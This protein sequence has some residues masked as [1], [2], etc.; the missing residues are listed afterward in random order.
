VGYSVV[1]SASEVTIVCDSVPT[2][3]AVPTN[4]SVA[5]NAIALSWTA[6]TTT[7]EIG[8]DPI[9]YYRLDF[10]NRKCYDDTALT[11]TTTFVEPDDGSWV[12][13][14]SSSTSPLAT[15]KTHTTTSKFAENK[16][17]NYRVSA[18]NG[19]GMGI[20]SSTISVQTPYKPTFMN[21]PSVDS[22]DEK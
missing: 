15:T 14:T 22:I 18:S 13:L 17:Y 5:Y 3:M 4:T 7:T 9:T 20:Y 12:E 16:L 6:L 10:F 21:T 19:V 8:R 11:C 2:Q 1:S